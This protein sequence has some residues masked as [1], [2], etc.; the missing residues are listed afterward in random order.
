[1][2]QNFVLFTFILKVALFRIEN[3]RIKQ[4]II[5]LMFDNQKI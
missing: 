4:K 2:K 1:M 3:Q 5:Q